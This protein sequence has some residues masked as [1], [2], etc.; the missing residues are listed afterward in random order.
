MQNEMFI[1]FEVR[2][3]TNGSQYQLFMILLKTHESDTRA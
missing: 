3:K 2:L 1:N